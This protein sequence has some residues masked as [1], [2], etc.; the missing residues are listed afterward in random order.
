MHIVIRRR[1]AF[2]ATDPFHYQGAIMQRSVSC[3]LWLGVLTLVSAPMA[4]AADRIFANSFDY[5]VVLLNEVNANLPGSQ[6]LIELRAMSDGS[7][8]GIALVQNPDALGGGTVLATLPDI[9]LA[10]GDLIVIHLA[11]TTGTGETITKSDCTDPAPSCFATA[12]DVQ[13]GATGITYSDRVLALRDAAGNIVD[14]VAFALSIGS[15]PSTYPGAVAYI[16]SVGQWL[17][18]DCSGSPCAVDSTPTIVQISAD[19]TGLGASFSGNSIGRVTSAADTNISV[20]WHVGA[21]TF[22]LA[23]P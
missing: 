19:W 10:A 2:L 18:A 15:V 5:A 8:L 14:A 16:Q 4:A 17:P 6:D 11:P 22:G 9:P 1:S 7:V 20:D 12:W 21:Q 23:N 3:R 13:G